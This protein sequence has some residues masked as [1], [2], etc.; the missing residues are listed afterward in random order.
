M[1]PVGL[2]VGIAG[3]AGLFSSCIDI[4]DRAQ[5]YRSFGVDSEDL[6]T[7]LDGHKVLFER[8]GQKVGLDQKGERLERHHHKALD[9]LRV[10]TAVENHLKT[11]NRLFR[12][13]ELHQEKVFPDRGRGEGLSSAGQAD[14]PSKWVRVGWAMGGKA[15]R[16]KRVALFGEL[17]SQLYELV[18]VEDDTARPDVFDLSRVQATIAHLEAENKRESI[19]EVHNWLTDRFSSSADIYEDSI[20]NRV[21]DTCDW[22]IHR[23]DFQSWLSAEFPESRPKLLWIHA[24]AG[25]GKTFLCSR[26]VEHTIST[27]GASSSIAYFFFSSQHDSRDDPYVAIR[28]W[29]SRIVSQN[30]AALQLAK[31]KL[32]DEP[33]QSATRNT[34]LR[35]LREIVL[36]IPSCTLIADGLDEVSTHVEEFLVDL[37]KA[38]EGSMTRVLMVSRDE[39][40]IREA[41]ADNNEAINFSEYRVFPEDTQTDTSAYSR[42]IVEKKL[43]NKA[44]DVR[45]DISTSM[46]DRC[47][48]QFLW[49]KLQSDS[50]RK[51]MNKKQLQ[52]SINDTP[53]GI[54]RVY[55][56]NWQRITAL[57]EDERLRAIALLRWVAF[58]L[59]PLTVEQI[60]EAVLVDMEDHD[61]L[62][63]DI[64]GLP[65]SMD[66]DYVETQITGLCQSLVEIRPG[67]S[68]PEQTDPDMADSIHSLRF[69]TVHLT[70]FS[71]REFLM[72]A[73]K[74]RLSP[75]LTI[76][77]AEHA[78]MARLCLQYISCSEVWQRQKST[79][80]SPRA[81]AFLDYAAYCWARHSTLG[82][83]DAVAMELMRELFDRDNPIWTH[84]ST[85]FGHA[86]RGDSDFIREDGPGLSPLY[87]A[88]ML[89][90]SAVVQHLLEDGHDPNEEVR[91]NLRALE[92]A[93]RNRHTVIVAELLQA[94]ADVD[95]T[96]Q[97]GWAVL[98]VA[99]WLK[100]V[101]EMQLLVEAGSNVNLS[102]AFGSTPL[103]MTARR[104]CAEGCKLLLEAG[105][106]VHKTTKGGYPALHL[107]AF[108]DDCYLDVARLLLDAGG[109][110]DAAGEEG[111]TPLGFA[112]QK[113]HVNM[114][115]LFID[116]GGDI[117]SLEANGF[118]LLHDAADGGSI[119]TA[120]IL[121]DAGLDVNA[122][123]T[124][125]F[126]VL[127][128]AAQNGHAEMVQ[129]LIDNSADVATRSNNG[130]TP[131]HIAAQASNTQVMRILLDSG[132]NADAQLGDGSTPLHLAANLDHP[133]AVSLLIDCGANVN[134]GNGLGVQPLHLAA[135]AANLVMC[136][137]LIQAGADL[138]AKLNPLNDE[139]DG[140]QPL[141]YAVMSGSV[142]V[143]KLLLDHGVDIDALLGQGMTALDLAVAVEFEDV[144]DF[145]RSKGATRRAV[146]SASETNDEDESRSLGAMT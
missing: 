38:V 55:E 10:L 112:A 79:E 4:V 53:S 13:D 45:S 76:E 85:W 135:E 28:F 54:E 12:E 145:L 123:T 40:P 101:D 62:P 21:K 6:T 29:I 83:D 24:P 63:I 95:S 116:A 146:D 1:E 20:R 17:V 94:G 84:W 48:G 102:N 114:L 73:T 105:A 98:H 128:V 92:A 9:S 70:H 75:G 56:R 19:K 72:S 49:V 14:K 88:S 103:M 33:G 139:F 67:I 86:L 97:Q 99:A 143:T 125:G 18:S 127:Y 117:H 108:E 137:A 120:R 142:A 100:Y 96:N 131:L 115:E 37:K 93:I 2:A 65:D 52:K 51:G 3:L 57:S 133:E 44:E 66:E 138:T 46:A 111:V 90:Q 36:K 32:L 106:D 132:A 5:T 7:Q 25:F 80:W 74:P 129:F 134:Q 144:A 59:I 81:F 109:H 124:A 104:G 122:T 23:D 42:A 77:S 71:V 15:K 136:E 31:E 121:L 11:I 126:T 118:T 34:L 27:L 82:A 119:S 8:W 110:L 58:G 89:G 39:G 35:L 107:A 87:I 130:E 78:A 113:G 26:L 68:H 61:G 64:D 47:Q 43:S 91:A 22:M 60:T 140:A 141:H 41:L 69:A 30:D 16:M 50:L